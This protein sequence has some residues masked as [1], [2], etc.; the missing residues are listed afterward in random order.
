MGDGMQCTDHPYRSTSPGG[1]CAFCLQDKLGKLVSASSS[2]FVRSSTSSSSPSFRSDLPTLRLTPAPVAPAAAANSLSLSLSSSSTDVSNGG[3]FRHHN[4]NH[5]HH[6]GKNGSTRRARIPFLLTQKKNPKKASSS[7]SSGDVV[8]KR[9]KSTATPRSSRY[10]P[11]DNEDL[12]PR[13]RGFWSFL[14]LSHKKPEKPKT[15]PPPAETTTE[16][17][18]ARVE[19]VVVVVDEPDS[20]PNS[21]GS[22]TASFGRKV[23]RSRSVGCGSRSF[24]GDFFERISTGFGDCTLRRVESQREGRRS[25]SAARAAGDAMKGRVPCGGLFGGFIITSSSSSSSWASG[26]DHHRAA[27]PGPGPLVNGRNRNW[28][29]AFSSPRRAFAKPTTMISKDGTGRREIGVG[30]SKNSN[31]NTSSTTTAPNL[32]AIP[33]LLAV[34]GCPIVGE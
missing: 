28:A 25:T 24:S 1:I 7:S 6:E 34:R 16:P 22:N 32:A 14:H 20:S 5:N 33:S 11:S 18:V 27:T 3:G 2:S 8:L 30:A 4:H 17:A 9:S 26:E 15:V 10:L 23:S 12:S 13:R 21:S 29:W 19:Q 31:N